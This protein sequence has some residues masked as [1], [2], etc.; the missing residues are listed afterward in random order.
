MGRPKPKTNM[1]TREDI[2]RIAKR[3]GRYTTSMNYRDTKVD[4]KC[5]VLVSEGKL[6]RSPNFDRYNNREYLYVAPTQPQT[7]EKKR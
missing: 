6:R 5:R 4:G 3:Y 7:N 1:H 2:M